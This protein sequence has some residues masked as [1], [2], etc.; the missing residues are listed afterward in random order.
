MHK[1]FGSGNLKGRPRGKHTS[2]RRWEV[3]TK[4]NIKEA[5]CRGVGSVHQTQDGVGSSDRAL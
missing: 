4:M 1:H 2:T 3:N 5:G